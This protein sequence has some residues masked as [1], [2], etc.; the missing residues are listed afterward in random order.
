MN[1]ALVIPALNPDAR[2]PAYCRELRERLGAPLVLVDDGSRPELRP[3]FDECLRACGRDR[4]ELLRHE[5]NRGKGRALKTAF[6]HL[7]RTRS[8]LVGCVTCDADGQHAPEDVVRCAERLAANPSALVLGCRRF[9]GP[10]VPFRSRLG[11]AAMRA[12]FLLATRRRLLDTQTGLRGIPAAFMRELLSVPGERFEFET[13]MLLRI[14][15]RPLEQF[16]IRTVYENGNRDSH[17]RPFADSAA[18]LRRLLRASVLAFALSALAAAALDLGLFALLFGHVLPQGAPGR[19]FLS[20]AIARAVSLSFNYA[21][22][23]RLVFQIPLGTE[24]DAPAGLP[25]ARYLALAALILAG[26]WGFT[27]L[28]LLLLPNAPAP[29]VKA[30]VDGTLFLV[31]Y[32]AQRV[33]VFRP[34]RP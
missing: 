12:L 8:E 19:L 15:R 27:K 5:T 4:V 9:G 20:V 30:A 6:E 24:T 31:S 18:I 14:G 17:F 28:G 33:W 26:S 3:V 21:C 1:V 34:R 22:N 13:D 23:R 2:L 11:N 10:G 32:A 25:F 7:L 29:L 16:P